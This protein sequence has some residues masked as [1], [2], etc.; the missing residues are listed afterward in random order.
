MKYVKIGIVLLL[1]PFIF[2]CHYL[3]IV[4]DNIA[5]VDHVFRMRST[6]EQYLFTCYSYQP[7]YTSSYEYLTILGGDEMWAN[8]FNVNVNEINW[9]IAKGFQNVVNPYSNYFG[10]GQGG[11]G[12]FVAIRD[13]N[14]F[15]DNIHKVPDMDDYEKVR[16]AAEAKFLKAYYHFFL[17]R[18]Y[19]PIPLIDKNLPIT[20]TTSEVRVKQAPVDS[21]VEFIARLLDEA[22][23]ELPERID[24]EASEN[25]R[26]TKSIALCVKAQLLV[27][28]ASPLFNGNS[29]YGTFKGKEGVSL[30][31]PQFDAQKWK[32]AADA[33]KVAIDECHAAGNKLYVFNPANYPFT[34]SPETKVELSVR[35]SVCERWN[36]EVVW[37]STSNFV[38]T[39]QQECLP[40]LFSGDKQAGTL[41]SFGA[42][43]KMA[44]L[45]YTKNGV[46]IS[47]D[48]TWDYV[49][50]YNVKVAAAGDF[51][52]IKPA[53]S[54]ALLNFDREV[55]FYADLGF[56][57]G[58]WYGH[59]RFSDTSNTYLEA[60]L[61]QLAN[62]HAWAYSITGYWPKKLVNP[63][64]VSN[65]NE[66]TF[67]NYLWP[68]IRLA[69]MYLLYAEALNESEGPTAETMKWID[70]VRER[71]GLKTVAESW[72]LFSINPGAYQQK[73]G[74]RKIIHQERLIEMAF[75]G[76]RFWDL[77]RW[78]EAERVLNEPITGWNYGGKTAAE[79]YTVKSLY[80]MTFRKRDYLWPI[81]ENDLIVN[82]NLVQNPGW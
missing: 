49:N 45:F 37:T 53:Y 40:R 47:E 72:T 36:K 76:P 14:T 66:I 51:L 34:L 6:A 50:R 20:S 60:K 3:D 31:N 4:P 63:Q 67:Q 24:N 26:I 33:C 9:N 25:G 79:Y 13:C 18:M 11:R 2:A 28:A 7:R 54:T 35:N 29:D 82:N 70:L 75:E 56:D 44:E 57:G 30:F 10:G 17:F 62:N 73:D 8:E 1:W 38:T 55:R 41:S 78:K 16:W 5:T 46:P 23:A 12:M 77:R 68:V 43:L 19:G 48:K 58:R 80:N 22:A 32:R 59:G 61:G 15:L 74:M 39:L 42:P 27:T 69:D 81:M 52:R 21:C 65:A 64:T 71:A